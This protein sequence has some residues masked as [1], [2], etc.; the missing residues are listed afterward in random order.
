MCNFICV[1]ERP[2]AGRARDAPARIRAAR[3]FAGRSPFFSASSNF[4]CPRHTHTHTQTH[5]LAAIKPGPEPP[6]H[7]AGH[8][9][10]GSRQ[11][12]ALKMAARPAFLCLGQPRGRRGRRRR[13]Q[14][15]L[16]RPAS[17]APAPRPGGAPGRPEPSETNP[18]P[19]RAMQRGCWCAMIAR[20]AN[21]KYRRREGGRKSALEA[22]CQ[23]GPG[24]R[25]APRGQPNSL[26]ARTCA[27]AILSGPPV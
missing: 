25:V 5:G 7:L 17:G 10:A 22:A 20:S 11:P 1:P 27:G 3:P 26:F 14:S 13:H 6:V 15:H 19:E 12:G 4:I 8:L 23:A 2:I 16:C 9:A 21:Q 24:G 18:P